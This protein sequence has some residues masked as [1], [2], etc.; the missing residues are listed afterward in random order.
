MG[1]RVQVR[2]LNW[3]RF[4]E[5]RKDVKEPGWLR[6]EKKFPQSKSLFGVKAADRY[7]FVALM[8]H[9]CD[10]Q[11]AALDFDSSWFVHIYGAG[12]FTEDDFVSALAALDGKVIEWEG[13]SKAPVPPTLRVRNESDTSTPRYERTNGRTDDPVSGETETPPPK[14]KKVRKRKPH[15]YVP[16]FEALWAGYP[17]AHHGDKWEAFQQWDALAP[18]DRALFGEAMIHVAAYY[19]SPP[20]NPP[21]MKHFERFISKDVWKD[22]VSGPPPSHARGKPAAEKRVYDFGEVS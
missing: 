7:V 20:D 10:E 11:S 22:W 5:K 16:E 18:D 3:E 1:N 9:A 8:C 6:L 12:A 14:V 17:K 21:Y 2:I 4:N 19:G 13:A 15:D